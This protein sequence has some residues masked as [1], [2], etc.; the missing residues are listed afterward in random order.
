MG[1][2]ES[3][4]QPEVLEAPTSRFDDAARTAAIQIVTRSA[5]QPQRETYVAHMIALALPYVE[6]VFL[7]APLLGN[8]ALMLAEAA[9]AEVMGDHRNSWHQAHD[10]K[11]V[12][13]LESGWVPTCD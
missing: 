4:Q 13:L 11:I 6:N 2:S 1:K 7:E 10:S 5:A 12:K 9:W 8:H 3:E